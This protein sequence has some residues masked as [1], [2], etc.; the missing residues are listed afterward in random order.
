MLILLVLVV[1]FGVAAYVVSRDDVVNDDF[2]QATWCDEA[3]RLAGAGE[4]LRG[5]A[6]DVTV[7]ELGALKDTLFDVETLAPFD[8]WDDIAA[9][10]DFLLI[11]AQERADQ[12]W[13]AAYEAARANK[14]AALDTAIEALELDLATCG[15]R[16]G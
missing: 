6:D 11:A 3:G 1:G 9:S 10:A 2:D 7:D 14:E 13:P 15:I 16:L 12:P 4:T 8:L 5:T